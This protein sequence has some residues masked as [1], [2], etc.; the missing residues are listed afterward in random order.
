MPWGLSFPQAKQRFFL[1]GK[2]LVACP[3][4]DETLGIGIFLAMKVAFY[5]TSA[6]QN[7]EGFDY[8]QKT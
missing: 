6:S 5:R 1:R 7:R 3:L 4:A 8:H 2:D